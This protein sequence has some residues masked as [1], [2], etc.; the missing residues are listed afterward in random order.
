MI[1]ILIIILCI[2]LFLYMVSKMEIC[3]YLHCIQNKNLS[4]YVEKFNNTNKCKNGYKNIIS[5]N[6][7]PS[8]I[9]N[10][11]KVINSLLDQT[12]KCNL[13]T[14]V[15]PKEYDV[16]IP[17]KLKNVVVQFPCGNNFGELNCIIPTI[18]REGKNKTNIIVVSCDRIWGR[19]YIETLLRES[20]KYPNH[21]IS[22]NTNKP[23]LRDGCLFRIDNF[24][25]DF[26]K[27][28]KSNIHN[29]DYIKNYLKN[30]PVKKI[31]YTK[32]YKL[33]L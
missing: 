26:I 4:T 21:I 10:L 13:I 24:D 25:L 6:V 2:I 17:M 28:M 20:D 15:V 22:T 18:L 27:N 3:R 16:S 9:K 31:M 30:I 8:E 19:D 29:E 12:I 7:K 23:T 33:L 32:N 11:G 1:V 14:I 5:I